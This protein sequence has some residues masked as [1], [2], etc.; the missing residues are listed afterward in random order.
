MQ[1]VHWAVLAVAFGIFGF[2]LAAI[3]GIAIS[4]LMDCYQDVR[5]SD[6]LPIGCSIRYTNSVNLD[7]WR[8]PSGS[9]IRTE[10]H[11][12]YRSTRAYTLGQG[13][14]HPESSYPRCSYCFRHLHGPRP[15][16]SVGKESTGGYGGEV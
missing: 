9:Y 16:V 5:Q 11:L 8:C 12:A 14:G 6:I 1:G 4:Y 3:S 10:H 13:D 2:A 15:I 7:H